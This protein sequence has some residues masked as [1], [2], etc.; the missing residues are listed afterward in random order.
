MSATNAASLAFYNET[1]ELGLLGCCL[2]GNLAIVSDIAAAVPLDLLTNTEIHDSYEIALTLLADNVRPSKEAMQRAWPLRYRDR[3]IPVSMWDTALNTTPNAINWDFYRQGLADT[4]RRRTIRDTAL[5]IAEDVSDTTKPVTQTMAKMEAVISENTRTRSVTATS[6]DVLKRHAEQMEQACERRR[7][8]LLSGIPTGIQRLDKLTDGLQFGEMAI[9]AARPSIGKTAL[10]LNFAREAALSAGIPVLFVTAE[11]SNEALMRR[12]I[13]DVGTIPLGALKS[14]NLSGSERK[15]YALAQDTIAN[16]PIHFQ[17]VIGNASVSEVVASIRAAVRKHKVKL[18]VVDYLQKLR[19]D[20]KHEKKT[21]EVA[22]VSGALKACAVST[23][24]AMV[25]LAQVNR[26]S[27]DRRPGTGDAAPLRCPA[28]CDLAES[29]Q[30]E[31]DAD[32]VGLLHRDRSDPKVKPR[33]IIAKQR[34]G[35]CG[36][37]PLD[38]KGEFQRFTDAAPDIH[39]EDTEP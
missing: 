25:A 9:I 36:P 24:V 8:G 22:E 14:G 26:N 7:K 13:A 16:A 23:G 12:L 35:E 17:N 30:I 11:M 18:V 10:G 1:D 32:L 5:K 2:K 21:Y 3:P 34:D 37:V 29:G 6:R 39:A 19:A 4:Q 27:E 31:R 20:G 33:L 38:F 15:R 28:L